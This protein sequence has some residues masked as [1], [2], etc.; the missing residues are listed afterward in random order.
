MNKI[1]LNYILFLSLLFYLI[2]SALVFNFSN[3]FINM[4]YK[5]GKVIKTCI[6]RI[7]GDRRSIK[8]CQCGIVWSQ[9]K[10]NVVFISIGGYIGLQSK[11]FFVW[12]GSTICDGDHMTFFIYAKNDA[13]VPTST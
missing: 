7:S 6:F 11:T 12:H 10:V 13:C 8:L 9:V 3:K 1:D 5:L 4:I 2:F